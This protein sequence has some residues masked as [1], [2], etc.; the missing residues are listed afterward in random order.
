MA[1]KKSKL[2]EDILH[3]ISEGKL[4]NPFTKEEVKK[5]LKDKWA[6]ATFNVFFTKHRVGNPGGYTEYYIKVDNGYQIK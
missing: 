2:H 4:K 1:K 5:M 6:E 3:L